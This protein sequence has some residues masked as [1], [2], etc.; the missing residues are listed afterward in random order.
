MT[1]NASK[2]FLVAYRYEDAEWVLELKA[3]DVEDAKARLAALPFA[4][5]DGELVARVPAVLGPLAFA[6]A[7]LRNSLSRL[8]NATA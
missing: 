6:V 1:T 5:L 2:T 8:L 3:R 7:V 4:R